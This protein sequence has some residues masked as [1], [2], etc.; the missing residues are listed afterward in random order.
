MVV[1]NHSLTIPRLCCLKHNNDAHTGED[2]P[3]FSRKGTDMS[4]QTESSLLSG[5]LDVSTFLAKLTAAFIQVINIKHNAETVD[6][7]VAVTN[8]VKSIMGVSVNACEVQSLLPG[9]KA[10]MLNTSVSA[11]PTEVMII[12][13]TPESSNNRQTEAKERDL[14]N[15]DESKNYGKNIKKR[16]NKLN[17]PT[18]AGKKR[19]VDQ[20]AKSWNETSQVSER[21]FLRSGN[22]N[23]FPNKH[24]KWK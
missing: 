14:D 13:E 7:V 22:N 3:V 16:Q 15:I 19:G 2:A 12:P 9:T 20:L 6:Q 1:G 4:T 8:I 21:Q 23:K 24:Q 10:Q 5:P 17:S 18:S 11:A